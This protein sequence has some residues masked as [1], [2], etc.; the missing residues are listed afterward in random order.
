MLHEPGNRLL[1]AASAVHLLNDACFAILYP[2]LPL[3]AADLNLNYAQV[4]LLKA[5]FSGASSLLQIP[6]GMLGAS[7]GEYLVL[8]LGNIWVGLGVVAMG[9]AGSFLGLL[10]LAALAGLGGNAQHPLANSAVSQRTTPARMATALGTLNFAGDLGKFIG[11]VIAGVVAVRFGW[12]YGLGT[13][14]VITAL[15]TLGLLLRRGLVEPPATTEEPAPAEASARP[16]AQP[17][18]TQRGFSLL[19]LAGSLDNATRGAAL[20]FLP[21][22][23]A[24]K[25]LAASTVSLAFG[26]IFAGGAAGKFACGWLT[27]RFG[28]LAVIVVTETVTASALLGFLVSPAAAA[29]PLALGFGFVLNGTSSAFAVAVTGFIPARNRSR[30]YG[31]YF[32]AALLSSALAPL[33]YGQLGDVAGLSVVFIVMALLTLAVILAALPIRRA[34][35]ETLAGE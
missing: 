18:A 19:L 25:G 11:P 5:T 4:G 17:R 23:L 26:L 3:I 8:L 13:I 35:A 15:V 1:A 29:I 30:G 28:P 31:V 21:F 9:L 6:A 22:V 14:G 10:A 27:D 34:L 20:T 33:A 2:L 32:T 7:L 24:H 16:G 12:R